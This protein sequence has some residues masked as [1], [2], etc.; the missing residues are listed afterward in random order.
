MSKC[1]WI[2]NDYAGSIYHGMEYRNYYISR[3][4]VKLG[5]KVYIVSA[6][7]MHLFKQL[8]KVD[9][10]YTFEKIDEVEYIWIK[11]PHYKSSTDKKRVLK[12]FVFTAKLF[13]LP[14]KKM[15]KPDFIIA[16]PMAPFLIAPA[17]F[18]AKRYKSKLIYEI[19]DLW[20]LS[21]IELGGYSPYHPFIWF[22]QKFT[23]F[24]LKKSDLI[25]SVLQNSY[26]YLKKLGL[27]KQKFAYIPNGI[28]VKDYKNI[29]ELD[30]SVA[31]KIPKDKF[32][33]GYA[34]S[35]GLANDLTT[36]VLSAKYILDD[37]ISLVL[38][39][40][41]EEKQKLMDIAK[42]ENLKNVIFLDPIPKDEVQSL[43]RRF[44]VCYIS[45]KDRKLF[46]YGVSP[47]K[48]FEYLFAK[49][50]L[51]YAINDKN[52]IISSNN[53][54]IHIEK[55]DPKKIAKAIKKLSLLEKKE[56]IMMGQRGYEYVLKNHTYKELA[57]KYKD[58]LERL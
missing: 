14:L 31:S 43:L 44:D 35:I 15:Q 21:L 11:V 46:E 26:E 42:K 17:Y 55:K 29:K 18:F 27:K 39:G 33:V 51:I 30:K 13:F 34:G 41:G 12:W 56:L 8:P 54:G 22:M 24:A 45:L 38:V 37:D 19:K 36:F 5:Y 50:P 3:E 9:K 47:N 2:F 58:I 48:L 28:C 25:I 49:K 1:V 52:S 4:L 10:D 40:D 23:N 20:P 32:I 7:Y 53:L 57:Q 6:S 16:S